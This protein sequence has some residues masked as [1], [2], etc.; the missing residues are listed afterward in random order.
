M[1]DL[2]HLYR[3]LVCLF[4]TEN[5]AKPLALYLFWSKIIGKF[6][7]QS[8]VDQCVCAIQLQHSAADV[9]FTF[10]IM[11]YVMLL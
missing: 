1:L 7:L 11:L 2:Y 6:P 3:R 9:S 10:V 8:V 5:T 4:S